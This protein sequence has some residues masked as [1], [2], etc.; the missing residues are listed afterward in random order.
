MIDVDLID[1]KID[2]EVEQAVNIAPSSLENSWGLSEI[3]SHTIL[4]DKP[5]EFALTETPSSGIYEAD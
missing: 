2:A 4:L 3:M 1:F 5:P